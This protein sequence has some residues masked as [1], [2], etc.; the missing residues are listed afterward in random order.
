ML[1]KLLT[2]VRKFVTIH[3]YKWETL[4]QTNPTK[5]T[6]MPMTADDKIVNMFRDYTRRLASD[7]SRSTKSEQR[8]LFARARTVRQIARDAGLI[9]RLDRACSA[10]SVTMRVFES[11]DY[12][13]SKFANA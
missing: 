5:E 13:W 8:D 4:P 11:N 3:P 12:N 10:D 1:N 7:V 2:L 9:N 6:E